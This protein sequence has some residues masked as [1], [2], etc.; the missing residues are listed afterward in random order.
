MRTEDE[1]RDA[2]ERSVKNQQETLRLMET[3]VARDKLDLAIRLAAQLAAE[4]AIEGILKWVL[5]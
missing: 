1:I 5:L 4:K 3:A 2:I